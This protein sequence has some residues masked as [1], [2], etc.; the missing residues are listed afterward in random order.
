MSGARAL[1]DADPFNARFAV[2]GEPTDLKPV[3]MHKGIM[4]ESISLEGQSGHSSNP[5]LGNNALDAMYKVI[6]AL[7]A[8]RDSW[9]EKYSNPGFEVTVP[10]LN[11]AAIHGGDAPN[12]I[13]RHCKL[14]FDV[15]VLPG[16]QNSEI[17]EII[18]QR[19]RQTLQGS[20]IRVNFQSLFEGVEPYLQDADCEL[21]KTAEA[22]TGHGADSAAFATEAPFFQALGMQTIVLGPGS[23]DCAH[24]ANEYIPIKQIEPA[25]TLLQQLIQRYC[26]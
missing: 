5:A 22:L 2:V 7:M 14:S 13:C 20:G 25:V 1:S 3:R 11:L 15:R 24:Q 16:M 4:M 19:T 17:R 23:I 21:V 8:L 26:M 10:T 9:A 6:S 18:R 12:R